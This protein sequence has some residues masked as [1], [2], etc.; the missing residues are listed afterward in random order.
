[1]SDGVA[2][3]RR[4]HTVTE[5]LLLGR[6]PWPLRVVAL[7][8]VT[9][10]AAWVAWASLPWQASA[11]Q[12]VAGGETGRWVRVVAQGSAP[13]TAWE[14]W[15]AALLFASAVARLR[16]GTVEPPA[17]RRPIEALSVAALRAGLLREYTL[18][19]CGLVGLSVIALAD[20]AR[21]ARYAIAALRGSSI[22]RSSLG[23]TAA[24]AAGLVA[25][26]LVLAV[27][28]AAF[29]SQLERLG[30]VTSS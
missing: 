21:A 25:A 10:L 29:R 6:L 18:A 22:A 8:A 4:R 1:M 5:L 23:A 12:A 9:A 11:A 19:R 14:G 2:T 17:G 27:W 7:G 16:R 28:A 13:Y 26:A 30:A 24:E 15:A 3:V 20:S